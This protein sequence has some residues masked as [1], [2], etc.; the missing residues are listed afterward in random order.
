[1]FNC[2]SIKGGIS[3]VDGFFCDGISAGLKPNDGLDL[4]FIRSDKLCDI[5]YLFTTNKFK[6]APLRYVEQNEITKS[7]FI[8]INA[9]N[10][11]AMTG[12]K[13]IDDVAQVM[14]ICKEKF[15]AQNPI[16]SSTG[17]IGVRLPKEKIIA[18]LDKININAKNSDNASKAIM[19]TDKYPKEIA[20][21]V[22]LENGEKFNIAG[23]AKGAGMIDPAMATMLCFIVTDAK[24][25]AQKMKPLLQKHTQTTFNAISVDGDRS[26]ND[27]V[28]LMSSASASYDESAFEFALHKVLEHLAFEIVSDGEGAK[29]M[30]AFEVVGAKDDS[31][32]QKCAKKLSNSLLVKTALFGE[33]PNWGRIAST[34][35]SSDIE[36][37]EESL[38]IYFN[39]LLVYDRGVVNFDKTIEEKAAKIMQQESFKILCNIGVGKGKFTA[40]GCDLG[41]EYVKIN[42]D[43]RT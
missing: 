18:G 29:K 26:T 15:G 31:Q 34:V 1:M 6:A 32:A 28:F 22:S 4:A 3:S 19:T 41:Y 5:S 2:I 33:D 43:Y 13:G 21:E 11:N 42:A 30:V 35:G 16:M 9:K 10:A 7:D 40:Y 38:Q 20:F 24:V 37:S 36:C 25:P 17:V 27:S 8:L 12:A 14:Q 23:I 39:T